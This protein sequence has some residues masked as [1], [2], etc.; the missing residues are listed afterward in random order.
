[1]SIQQTQINPRVTLITEKMEGFKSI[2]M[3]F[4]I[5]VG[6]RNENENEQGLTHLTEHM[7]FKGTKTKSAQDISLLVESLGATIDAFTS[8]EVSGIYFSCLSPNLERIFNLF[9]EMMHE[10]SFDEQELEKEK[11]VIL[12]EITESYE[13]PQEY[14]HQLFSQIVFP[15]HPLAF[16]IA[17]TPEILKSFTCEDLV[18]C[19]QNY[20]LNKR[21]CISIAGNVNHEELLDKLSKIGLKYTN[22]DYWVLPTPAAQNI[23]RALIF[24]TRPD[25]TQ[26]HTIAG[27]LTIPLKDERR[28][29]LVVLN[30][31]LGGSQS[32]RLFQRLREQEGLLATIYTFLDLYSDIGLFCGY[33][34][35]GIKN[36]EPSLMIAFEELHKL[37]KCGVTKDEF[38]RSVNYC[39]GMLALATEDPMSR[40]MRNANRFLLLGRTISVEESI[41]AFD[42]LSFDYING[43]V[44]LL[45]FEQYSAAIV[46]PITKNDLGKIGATPMKIIEKNNKINRED[47]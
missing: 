33:H 11:N 44:E 32:S 42:N 23:E 1:M 8:K 4:F 39:K 35:S 20:S 43:L 7:L 34:V 21:L 29:G 6:S 46:G 19:H 15:G 47:T 22:Q 2:S 37:K 40:M 45:N 41:A 25:L 17:G 31:I 9:F 10:A 12:Q 26:L 5:A 14:L 28:Y 30:N 36:R 18:R 13:N 38:N 24:Q 3:G 27:I 16:P